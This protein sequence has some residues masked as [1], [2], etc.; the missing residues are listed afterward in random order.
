M[1]GSI[2]SN[3][4]QAVCN[5]YQQYLLAGFMLHFD[6][7]EM[8]NPY[9]RQIRL[10]KIKSSNWLPPSMFF[11]DVC[12]FYWKLWST[13]ISQH[14]TLNFSPNLTRSVIKTWL[15]LLWENKEILRKQKR[16]GS[17]VLVS[18]SWK[19]PK[20]RFCSLLH[21]S[22]DDHFAPPILPRRQIW[23]NSGDKMP[24][25]NRPHSLQHRIKLHPKPVVSLQ[26]SLLLLLSRKKQCHE[27]HI[28]TLPLT[29][30]IPVHPSPL[31]QR[32]KLQS[33]PVPSY[34]LCISFTNMPSSTR[35]QKQEA[36][37][38]T[39]KQNCQNVHEAVAWESL[40]WRSDMG[41][42]STAS[43]RDSRHYHSPA[44]GSLAFCADTASSFKKLICLEVNWLEE[45]TEER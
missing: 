38:S 34:C 27:P 2:F 1:L 16:Y 44:L 35:G 30:S 22:R 40:A 14:I 32:D 12:N 4:V 6:T 15:K 29:H 41:L 21:R 11:S 45:L 17:L 31:C 37:S 25:R 9:H 13:N 23:I 5:H 36:G 20:G 24:Q 39:V 43:F 42:I 7:H 18:N 10:H 8:S 26:F 28:P 33:R 3:Q 19:T